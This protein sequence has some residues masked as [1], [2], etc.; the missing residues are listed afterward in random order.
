MMDPIVSVVITAHNRKKYLINAV[1]S[2]LNQDSSRKDY[3]IIVVKNFADEDIDSFLEREGIK[4]IHTD[5]QPF[6]E[7]LAIGIDNSKGEVISFLDDDDE[8]SRNKISC[9]IEAFNDQRV[10][11]HHSSIQTIDESG[12]EHTD[13]L[14]KNI[15]N[16]LVTGN[17]KPNDFKI[18]MKY[19]LDW[20]MSAISCQANL[21]KKNSAI[22]REARASLDKLT[23]LLC[24]ES[25][26]SLYFDSRRLTR[27][28]VHESLTTRITNR[29]AFLKARKDFYDRSLK[30]L[31]EA[32]NNY[33]DKVTR[34]LVDWEIIHGK[35]LVYFFSDAEEDRIST[36][37]IIHYVFL[38]LSKR[39]NAITYWA[40]LDLF[41]KIM[42]NMIRS[43]FYKRFIRK[44]NTYI[45]Q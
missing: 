32:S 30:S 36:A 21:L 42:P 9:L 35:L 2:V 18:V 26:G 45:P 43:S 23:F 38:S 27:Y 13:G 16:T 31:I 4:C 41:R 29:D 44:F 8:F 20:Y 3:E 15:P 5:A 14:S 25:G 24:V 37:S 40:L 1:K 19:K 12:K 39:F 34:S 17:F 10:T 7:K 28:R 6:G 22:I 33:K 11:Y